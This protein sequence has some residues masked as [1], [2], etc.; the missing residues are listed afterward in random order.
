M[1]S[2][3]AALA[4]VECSWEENTKV[5]AIER[6]GAF[7]TIRVYRGGSDSA[8]P[9]TK[10]HLLSATENT[11]GEVK[12]FESYHGSQSAENLGEFAVRLFRKLR[13]EKGDAR[14]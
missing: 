1:T 5:C 8:H 12:H 2:F 9:S 4:T 6:I 7:P 10:H 13:E 3:S 14:N 11:L